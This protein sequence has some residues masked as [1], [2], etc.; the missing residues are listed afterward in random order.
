MKIKRTSLG[1]LFIVLLSTMIAYVVQTTE[2]FISKPPSEVIIESE[3]ETHRCG[4]GL[5]S[6]KG[7]GV[8]C[9]NGYCRLDRI[10]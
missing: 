2:G 9:I 1:I 6:C 10:H 5:P 4:I 3:F 7:K 8:R